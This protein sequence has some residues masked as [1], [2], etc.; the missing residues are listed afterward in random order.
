MIFGYAFYIILA[1]VA[2]AFLF[3]LLRPAKRKNQQGHR[4]PREN[5]HVLSQRNDAPKP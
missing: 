5:E 4:P 1:L 2:I 3:I